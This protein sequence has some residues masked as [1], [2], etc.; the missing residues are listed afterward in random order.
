MNLLSAAFW[1]RRCIDLKISLIDLTGLGKSEVISL[2]GNLFDMSHSRMTR[3][4][5]K[6][7]HY[8]SYELPEINMIKRHIKPNDR[9]IELGVGIGAT[10]MVLC[11]LVGSESLC[12]FD[13]DERNISL[14]KRNFELSGKQITCQYFALTS[15]PDQPRTIRIAS[16]ANPTS[17]AAADLNR[18]DQESENEVAT[19]DFEHVIGEFEATALVM[20]IEGSEYDLL[21]KADGFASLKTIIMETHARHIGTEKNIAMLNR[22]T[23][24]GFEVAESTADGEVLALR[25]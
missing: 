11:D 2:H 5:I 12:V 24:A 19:L 25:R 23:Q 14:A 4:L 15:G 7:L 1:R 8:G 22:L 6:A 21:M 13:V 9:V 20:D 3:Q 17:S 18:S 16:S 10:S